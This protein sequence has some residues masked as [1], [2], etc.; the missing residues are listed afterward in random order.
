[1]RPLDE[2]I[3]RWHETQAQ[4]NSISE[5]QTA[6]KYNGQGSPCI[7]GL[8]SLC[9]KTFLL[10]KST[11]AEEDWFQTLRDGREDYA[12]R[13]ESLLKYVKH[14]EALAELSVD[15]LAD[16]PSSPWE[17]ARQDDAIRAEIQ[18]DVKRLPDEANYHEE[19]IQTLILDVL[20]MYCKLYP[21][22]GGYRQG[23]HELLAPIVH[24]LESDAI[25]ASAAAD[26]SSIDTLLLELVDISFIE[27]DAF[28]MFLTLMEHAQSFYALEPTVGKAESASQNRSQTSTIVERSQFIHQVCLQ[29]VDPELASHLT[30]IEILPQ[31][32]LIRWVRLLFSREFPFEQFLVLWDTIFAV[33][34]TLQLI[35]LI[36]VAMLVRIRW[37]LLEADYSVC[38]QLL[39]KYPAPDPVHG[40]HTFVDD[41]EY[42]RT[43]LDISGGATLIVR[44]TGKMPIGPKSP[45]ASRPSTPSFRTFNAFRQRALGA[46]SPL[47]S[48]NAFRNQQASVEAIFQGAAKG[49]RGVFERGEKLG[50]NQAVR[51]AVG[52]IKRNMQGFNESMITPRMVPEDFKGENAAV[53]LAAMEKRNQQL[54]NMLEETVKSLKEFSAFPL[55]EKAKSLELIEIAAAKI[56]FVK[57]YLEDPTMEL[58]VSNEPNSSLDNDAMETDD[59][60]NPKVVAKEPIRRQHKPEG[61]AISSLSL[62]DNNAV[63]EQSTVSKDSGTEQK[64]TDT[65][66][67]GVTEGPLAAET[68]IPERPEP[69]PTR[70]TLAQSS[71]SWMLEPNESVPS[72]SPRASIKSPASPSHKKRSSNNVSRE[73]NAFLF[74]E[75][76]SAVDGKDP[77]SSDDIF[78]MEPLKGKK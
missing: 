26:K 31:I 48:P 2:I 1:M 25:D 73:R 39:L 30:S 9:W 69:I 66:S 4:S 78:G 54:A 12:R 41:A 17:T 57:I 8:R 38:L 29:K 72:L 32:F 13:R 24:V 75:V 52:E 45:D 58:L 70:S 65:S 60:P 19:R 6:V 27:H 67:N 44:Y 15:P 71:F 62:S 28:L 46:K 50:I 21:E 68:V 3:Q 23:M 34:P 59:K 77:L 49:A 56:Q 18:Q 36:C 76:T 53:A 47:S 5:L 40:P 74:G 14:P 42:L 16:V 61:L 63:P 20:F 10:S 64:S 35:D 51:D 22:R 7:I 11:K 55:D 33:D 37:Q 43:H